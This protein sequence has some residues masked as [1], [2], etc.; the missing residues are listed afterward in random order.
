MVPSFKNTAL[1]FLEILFIQH[2]TIFGCKQYDVITD[3]ICIIEKRLL[4]DVRAHCYCASL[5]RTLFIGHSRA[6]HVIF[7][8][9]H[10]FENSTKH[11]ADDLCVNLVCECFCWMLSDPHFFFRQITSFSDAFH[12]TK[13]QK[14]SVWEVLIIS[15]ILFK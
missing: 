1:I 15:H 9:A 8:R 12:H 4:K 10:R 2:F 7:K 6:C 5:V 11:R 14:K 3:V 13:K